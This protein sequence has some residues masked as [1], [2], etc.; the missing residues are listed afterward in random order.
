[1]ALLNLFVLA[2]PICESE[3]QIK[4]QGLVFVQ[5][6]NVQQQKINFQLATGHVKNGD[7]MLDK[8][9]MKRVITNVLQKLGDKYAT[10][11]AIELIYN[12]GLVESKYVY[13]MQ[14]GGSNIA[15][16]FFQIEP[17][18][19]VD[20]IKNYLFYRPELMKDASRASNVDLKYF[21]DPKDADWKFILT[22]NIA[23][24]IVMCRIHYRRVPKKLPKTIQ[25]QSSYWKQYYNTSKG[26]G[27]EKH[28]L[29]IV[30]KYG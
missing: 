20:C 14:K 28:F 12:T 8:K 5:D 4:K 29:E 7:E 17:W 21:T 10:E 23:A 19:S 26:A 13:L 1:M 9:Q 30:S 11:D 22:T 6:I 24:Q 27:T 25:Q 15:R 18:T 2:I 3:N 16:G